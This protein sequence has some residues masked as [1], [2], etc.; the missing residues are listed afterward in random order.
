MCPIRVGACAAGGQGPAFTG[1]LFLWGWMWQSGNEGDILATSL[2]SWCPLGPEWQE[3]GVHAVTWGRGSEAG[4]P[5]EGATWKVGGTA[6]RPACLRRVSR[7]A[8]RD[9]V[10]EQ[11]AASL[12]VG[13]KPWTDENRGG[14]WSDVGAKRFLWWSLEGWQQKKLQV[15]V[16]LRRQKCELRLGCQFLELL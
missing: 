8:W 12:K 10:P 15:L 9:L 13:W 16:K 14:M 4:H 7:G 1:L 2:R 6:G 11:W 3:G 5:Q